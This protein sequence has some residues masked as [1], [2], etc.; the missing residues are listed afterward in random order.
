MLA[1][2]YIHRNRHLNNDRDEVD[3]PMRPYYLSP[4]RLEPFMDLRVWMTPVKTQDDMNTCC[5]N[6]FAAICEYLIR[7][8][9]NRPYTMNSTELSRL[10]IYFNGQR[11]EQRTRHVGDYGAHQESIART[12]R[13]YGICDEIF[14]PYRKHLLNKEPSAVAYREA[15]KYTAVV[16]CVPFTIK[17][18]ETCLH[19][20]IPVP[21]N[22]IMDEETEQIIKANEGFLN[23][24]Q[25]NDN[26]I[27][28]NNL[29]AVVIVG[30]DSRKQYFIVQNSRGKNWGYYGYFYVPYSFLFSRRCRNFNHRLWTVQELRPRQKRLPDIYYPVMH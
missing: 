28:K 14:W 30:Y 9:N 4:E 29:H 13:R 5:A 24:Q 10:F 3:P 6:A 23:I 15:R 17:A 20:Q 16:F 25:L 7:R 21:I 2:Y 11:H 8:T 18:I 19:H 1:R 27:D 12:I 26:T 22:M